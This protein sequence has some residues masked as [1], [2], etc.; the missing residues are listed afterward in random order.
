MCI[1]DSSGRELLLTVGTDIT[2]HKRA[3]Q[4]LRQSEEQYRQVVEQSGQAIVIVEDGIIQ[5]LNPWGESALGLEVG[6]AVGLPVIDIVH[7]EDRPYVR[8]LLEAWTQRGKDGAF[9]L[10]VI[11][12]RARSPCQCVVVAM[13]RTQRVRPLRLM[14]RRSK[15]VSYTHLDVYK[16]QP[17]N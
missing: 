5:Y 17:Q 1:R 15:A 11:N 10:R 13:P 3:E 16:R 12:L 14:T 4:V 6:Q 7:P 9:D 8:E 2:E